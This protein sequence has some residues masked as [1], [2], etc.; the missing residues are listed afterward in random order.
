[1]L[2]KVKLIINNAPLT[3]VYQNTIKTYLTPN[4]L[5]FGRQTNT[6]ST[7]VKNLTVLSSTIASAIIS[8]IGGETTSI[9]IKYKLP[10]N[11]VVLVYDETMPRLF[12]RIAIV[13]GV[14]LSRDSETKRSDSPLICRTNQGTAFYTTRIS[15]IK[16][17]MFCYLLFIKIYS[18]IMTKKLTIHASK[19]RRKMHSMNPLSKS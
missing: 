17:L 14:L 6:N 7:L 9:K 2:I 13:T 3:Y 11:Y 5:L 16:E 18:L 1:M 15:V 10:K 19:Y 4:H 12:W 8:G